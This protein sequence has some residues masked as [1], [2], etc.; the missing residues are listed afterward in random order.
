MKFLKRVVKIIFIVTNYL[1]VGMMI[2]ADIFM[3]VLLNKEIYSLALYIVVLLGPMGDQYY[4]EWVTLLS[5]IYVH[6][7]ICIYL[8]IINIFIIIIIILNKP[9]GLKMDFIFFQAISFMQI[10]HYFNKYAMFKK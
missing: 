8:I 7:F 6:N 5:S 10:L 4:S 1:L 2:L 9:V 3:Y